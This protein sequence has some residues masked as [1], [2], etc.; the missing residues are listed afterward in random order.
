MEVVKRFAKRIL[1]LDKGKLIEDCSLSHFVRNE[2]EHPALKPL[3]AE[4]QPQLPDNFA[5]QLQPNRSSGCNE[6]VARVYLEGRHVTDPLFSELATKF[7]VQTRLLQ[8]GVNEIGDQSACDIIVS[9]SG[10]KCDEAIQ[11]VNQKAQAF[12]LL[13]WLCHQ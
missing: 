7:G 6:A 2:P 8:G 9:L 12:R 1:V 10:E 3:L 13:G 4:I 11:W 5:K